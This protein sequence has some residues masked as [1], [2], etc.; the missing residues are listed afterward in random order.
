M[1]DNKCTYCGIEVKD[2]NDSIMVPSENGYISL[3]LRCYNKEISKA[4]GI[5]YE[6]IPLHPVVIKD[7]DGI[8]HEFHFSLRLMGD[9]QVLSSYEV[10]GAD[11]NGYEFNTIGD[12]EDG[13]FPLFSKLYARM[14]KALG[15]KHIYKD[16][17]TDSW[18]MT[19]DDVVRGR[20]DCA[21]D[22]YDH[23]MIPM[24]VIDGKEI[25]WKEFGHMLMTFEGFNFK[26]QI[27]DQSD[28]I[29]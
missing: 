1:A 24:L 14:L 12:T 8:E 17:E 29:D 28:E 6:D 15:R 18:Q 22:S 11:S 7:T 16:T 20:I 25:S 13:I 21:E 2:Y 10:K 9:Q 3:C 23:S 26:L 5:E 27:F 4:A 19:E